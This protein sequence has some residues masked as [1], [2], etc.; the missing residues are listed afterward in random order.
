MRPLHGGRHSVPREV[1]AFNQR[2]RLL[3]ALVETVTAKGYANATIA[4]IT[5][6]ASVSRRTFYE[7]FTDKAECFLAAYDVLDAHLLEIT[8]EAMQAKVTWADRVVAMLTSYLS[9]FAAHPRFAQMYMIESVG[10]GEMMAE[11]REQRARR[12]VSLLEAGR[13]QS[14][15]SAELAD[16]LEDALAGGVMTLLFRR[17]RA[18]QAEELGSFA[19][20]LV[21]FVLTPYLGLEGARRLATPLANS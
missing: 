17:V 8:D 15:I 9:Y 21:E 3:A 6:A 11:R 7:H 2:E 1:V 18:G 5:S 20:A 13:Q 4:D 19:P 12:F 14:G 10:V 16:G